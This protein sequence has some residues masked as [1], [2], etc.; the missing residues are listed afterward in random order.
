MSKE[1]AHQLGT[2]ISS[3]I[4]WIELLEDKY[5]TETSFS[6]MKQD[7]KRLETITDDSLK[8]ALRQN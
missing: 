1:T 2:P 8:L 5:G 6:E 4:A 3:L 7:I